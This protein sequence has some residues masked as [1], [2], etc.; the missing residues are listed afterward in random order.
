MAERLGNHHAPL[1]PAR[2]FYKSAVALIPKREVMQQ[3][4][5]VSGVRLFSEK[6]AAE[7]YRLRNRGEDVE[8]HFLG[9]EADH[10]AGGAV[11]PD[12]IMAVDGHCAGG[13][14]DRAA[15]DADQGRLAGAVGAEQ[16]ENLATL[17][18]KVNGGKRGEAR[19]VGLANP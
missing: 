6:A 1:H 9:H 3:A 18:R 10:R 14:G 19:L 8:R 2:Q 15:D 11:V 13:Q 7:A 12:D 4:L 17:E 16:R 5:E